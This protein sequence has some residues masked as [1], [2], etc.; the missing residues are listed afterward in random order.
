MLTKKQ[1]SQ[2]LDELDNCKRPL[3]FFHDD[4][5]GLCSFLLLYRYKLEG[6]GICVK[7]HPRVDSRFFKIVNE[8][9]P[10]KIFLLDLAILDDEFIDEFRKIPIV[11]IDHH[12]PA[13]PRGVKYFNP[14]VENKDDNTCASQLCYNVIKHIHPENVWIAAAGI[15]GDWQL[16]EATQEFSAKFPELLPPEVDRPEVALFDTPFAKLV[17]I[18]N[19]TLKG[20]TQDVMKCVRILTRVESPYELLEG[21][22]PRTR[23]LIKRYKQINTLYDQLLAFAMKKVSKSN[24]LV[25]TYTEDKMSFSGELSNELLYRYPNK[26][27]LVA[28]EKS[29]EMKCSLRSGQDL[30]IRDAL[31]KAFNGVEGYGGGHEHACGACINVE[32][33]EKF[34]DQLKAEIK[35]QQKKA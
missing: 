6:K 35:E 9:E 15:V 8:F 4:S 25:V 31:E 26:V 13:E 22:T 5:D 32:D 21:Q 3:F 17:K 20:R 2:I 10:D 1:Y 30:N 29:G 23:Y 19:F 28:R 27:I 16:T 18:L 34:V 11:W 14:R 12:G 7:S 33:F 24:V